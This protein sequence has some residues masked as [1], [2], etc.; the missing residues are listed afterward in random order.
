MRAGQLRHRVIV[1]GPPLTQVPDG[2][3]GYV[4]TL[5]VKGERWATIAPATAQDVE[6]QVPAGLQGQVTHLVT[7]RYVAG[8]TLESVVVFGARRLRVKGLQ[9][10][11]ERHRE[12]VL[13]CEE[14]P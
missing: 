14:R 13:A 11:D 4:E 9:D 2:N 3:G 1:V 5:T 7:M 8:I 12:L 6:R 10:V